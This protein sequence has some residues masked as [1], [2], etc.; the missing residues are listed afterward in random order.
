MTL[1]VLFGGVFGVLAALVG[2]GGAYLFG[3]SKDQRIKKEEQKTIYSALTVD[4]KAILRGFELN[5]CYLPRFTARDIFVMKGGH[6]FS[7]AS[8]SIPLEEISH[9][10]VRIADITK[11]DHEY[12]VA[13]A[14]A[15]EPNLV[16]NNH[17]SLRERT[18]LIK[19]VKDS[20]PKLIE[21]LEKKIA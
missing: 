3:F 15:G 4:L 1:E 10:L 13:V 16:Y 2:A 14:S 11:E 5:E 8:I 9:M 18:E 6:I 12:N 17:A 7:P 20:I 19:R 21:S